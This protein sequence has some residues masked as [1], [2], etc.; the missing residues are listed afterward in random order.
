MNATFAGADAAAAAEVFAAA[1]GAPLLQ[2]QLIEELRRHQAGTDDRM[3]LLLL[4][5]VATTA[6]SDRDSIL[7]P[8]FRDLTLLQLLYTQ[9]EPSAH[10]LH[11]RVVVRQQDDRAIWKL[12]CTDNRR[13]RQGTVVGRTSTPCDPPG[14]LGTTPIV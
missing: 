14:I 4:L 10:S 13:G 7:W 6:T 3:M 8:P 2:P 1:A 5:S 12:N 11:G 9:E